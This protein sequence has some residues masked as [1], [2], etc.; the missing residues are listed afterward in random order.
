[1]RLNLFPFS[2]PILGKALFVIS[3][4]VSFYFFVPLFLELRTYFSLDQSVEAD[5]V[6]FS[7]VETEDQQFKIGATYTYQVGSQEFTLSEIFEKPLFDNPHQL[8]K[9][10]METQDQPWIVYYS[11]RHPEI[12]SLKRSI[13][14]KKGIDFLL[15]ACIAIYF[16]LFFSSTA[17][18]LQQPVE[19]RM[20]GKGDDSGAPQ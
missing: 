5:R 3:C 19:E 12:S 11:R 9:S 20:K 1:M 17:Q 4:A 10:L 15:A 7:I 14:A 13:T 16:K 18:A 2:L 6:R 8:K